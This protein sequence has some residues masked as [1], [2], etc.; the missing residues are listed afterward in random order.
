MQLCDDI[1]KRRDVRE[2]SS[3]CDE[4]KS[5]ATTRTV[6]C[7]R[8]SKLATTDSASP[9][10]GPTESNGAPTAPSP[11]EPASTHNIDQPQV[12]IDLTHDAGPVPPPVG[13]LDFN[14]TAGFGIGLT[15]GVFINFAD[16]AKHW[17]VGGGAMTPGASTSV[18]ISQQP[19]SPG[20]WSGQFGFEVG[21]AFGAFGSS[22]GAPFAEVGAG[23]GLPVPYGISGTAYYTW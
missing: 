3:A 23:W 5:R 16:G 13:Y 14:V 4:E 9:G 2:Q 17:Y 19:V 22:G 6:T 8:H 18:N 10:G 7:T 11:A 20:Q 15:G 21:P 1:G 12:D